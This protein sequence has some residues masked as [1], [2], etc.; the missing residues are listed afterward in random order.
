MEWK[1]DGDSRMKEWKGR[2]KGGRRSTMVM[3]MV[4]MGSDKEW[5]WA[6]RRFSM[7]LRHGINS[8]RA[9]QTVTQ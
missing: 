6:Q 5:M 3:V 1:T 9:N 4:M 2:G 7:L 8:V